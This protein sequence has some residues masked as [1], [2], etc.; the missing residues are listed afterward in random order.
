M[1]ALTVKPISENDIDPMDGLTFHN[2][3]AQVRIGQLERWAISN[4][5]A[6]EIRFYQAVW[7]IWVRAKSS[8]DKK[9][10]KRDYPSQNQA[11]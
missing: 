2:F 10:P 4:Q 11:I 7:D 8:S 3:K 1:K 5:K 9:Q 6:K